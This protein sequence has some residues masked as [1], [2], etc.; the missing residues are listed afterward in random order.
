MH[1]FHYPIDRNVYIIKFCLLEKIS[2]GIFNSSPSC[3]VYFKSV[4]PAGEVLYCYC[5]YEHVIDFTEGLI[6]GL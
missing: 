1:H 6:F 4:H 2:I 5:Y 3:H